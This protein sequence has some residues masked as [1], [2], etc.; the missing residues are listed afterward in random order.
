[1]RHARTLIALLCLL[2][3]WFATLTPGATGLLLA[4]L[5]PLWFLFAAIV[6]IPV[7]RPSES[8]STQPFPLLR[9]LAPR[10]PPSC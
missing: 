9:L 5:V 6:S 4:V 10:P 8:S 3:V 2:A 1:M 7:G